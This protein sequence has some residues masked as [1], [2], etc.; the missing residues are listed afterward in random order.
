MLIIVCIL[1]EPSRLMKTRPNKTSLPYYSQHMC[2]SSAFSTGS[3]VWP[4]RHMLLYF[5][6]QPTFLFLP[7]FS[8]LRPPTFY[9]HDRCL[10][11]PAGVRDHSHVVGLMSIKKMI[12]SSRGCLE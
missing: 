5:L 2:D 11:Q 1:E 12:E 4:A 3:I 10:V 6:P 9:A 7:L 8:S